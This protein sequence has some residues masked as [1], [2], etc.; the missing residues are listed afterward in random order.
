MPPDSI[1]MTESAAWPRFR[2]IAEPRMVALY[3]ANGSGTK[4]YQGF[5][6][7]H[8]QIYLVP[9]YPLMYLYP[10][11]EQW[12]EELSGNWNWRN[13]IHAS[14]KGSVSTARGNG[15]IISHSDLES[16]YCSC[17]Y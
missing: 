3:T 9:G 15:I 17:K 11:W 10:H 4:L 6:D 12:K 8:P 5:L 7:G 14:C 1:S 2:D 13:I 16:V